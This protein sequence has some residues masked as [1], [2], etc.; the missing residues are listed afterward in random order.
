MI[1]GP[2]QVSRNLIFAVN[3]ST[4]A[5]KVKSHIAMCDRGREK[6]VAIGEGGKVWFKRL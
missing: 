6:G 3:G 5:V 1:G 2:F 4:A